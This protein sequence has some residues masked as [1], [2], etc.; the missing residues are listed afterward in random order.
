MTVGIWVRPEL[1]GCVCGLG[2][3]GEGAGAGGGVGVGVGIEEEVVGGGWCGGGSGGEEEEEDGGWV[4]W[5][6]PPSRWFGWDLWLGEAGFSL[7]SQITN[8]EYS[9]ERCAGVIET[10]VKAREIS[11][12][13]GKVAGVLQLARATRINELCSPIGQSLA[14][15][16]CPLESI[17]AILFFQIQR[18]SLHVTRIVLLAPYETSKFFYCSPPI[19]A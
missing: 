6:G 18:C 1:Q 16:D 10:D 3:E 5:V 19:L 2:R 9:R 11:N 8:R 17:S 12:I 7:W 13:S 4:F 14:P 15:T